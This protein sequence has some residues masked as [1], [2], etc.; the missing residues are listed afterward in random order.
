MAVTTENTYTGDGN[1]TRFAIT[2]EYL[3]ESDVKATVDDATSD[4]TFANATQ[5]EFNATPGNNS[6]IRIFRETN[7]DEPNTT[8]FSGSSIRAQDL[9]DN[10]SQVLFRTQELSARAF[11]KT[12]DTV[13]GDLKLKAASIVFEGVTFP[14]D[15]NQT[16]LSTIEPTN[17]DNTINLPNASGTL[18]VLA[19]ASTTQITSTPEELNKVDGYTGVATDL[20]KIAGVTDGTAA[21]SKAVVLDTNRDVSNIRNLAATKVTIATAPTNASDA[22]TKD[23]VDSIS[24]AG[25]IP[26]GAKGP[27]VTAVTSTRWRVNSI[28]T[29]Q[30]VDSIDFAT[31]YG[32]NFNHAMMGDVAI[33]SGNTITIGSGSVLTILK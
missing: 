8:F 25:A 13:T 5:I 26:A 18:P 33:T 11:D 9:N 17:N 12:G 6:K 1:T 3:Q 16:I 27:D 29:P 2:F 30:T 15:A 24:S 20:N 4:F 14:E 31:E 19:V 21:A 28:S 22:A 32:S 10:N 23:Y 7:T